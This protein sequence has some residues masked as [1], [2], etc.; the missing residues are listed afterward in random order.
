MYL[1]ERY[2]ID[3]DRAGA[4]VMVEEPHCTLSYNNNDIGGGGGLL[5][6]NDNNHNH[7]DDGTNSNVHEGEEKVKVKEKGVHGKSGNSRGDDKQKRIMAVG[8]L[9]DI[10]SSKN[11]NDEESNNNEVNVK[12][13]N[14]HH[15]TEKKLNNREMKSKLMPYHVDKHNS[16]DKRKRRP[17]LQDIAREDTKQ[18]KMA[19]GEL[20]DIHSNTNNDEE[21]NNSEV[22]VK[23]NNH[24]HGKEKKLDNREM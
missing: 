16:H 4:M 14:H 7:I 15:G 24:H 13:N 5:D 6:T 1:N 3:L 23:I 12:I 11:N 8:E 22:N 10:H 18:K 19:I 21:A 2:S 17:L 20:K 9:K